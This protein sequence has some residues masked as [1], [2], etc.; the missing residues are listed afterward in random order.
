MTITDSQNN[1]EQDDKP[2]GCSA[3]FTISQKKEKTLLFHHE[4]Q[5]FFI[6]WEQQ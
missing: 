3:I 1:A 6:Q 2:A 5:R 4:K